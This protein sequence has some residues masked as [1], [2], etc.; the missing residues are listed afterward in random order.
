LDF[1]KIANNLEEQGIIRSSFFVRVMVKVFGS[2]SKLKSGYYD[3][4]PNMSTMD[5]LT[6]DT[7]AHFYPIS[8]GPKSPLIRCLNAC[9]LHRSYKG[10]IGLERLIAFKLLVIIVTQSK[11]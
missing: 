8:I 2:Y 4:V 6:G 3:V 7:I 10:A 11:R 9:Y 5:L 1:L